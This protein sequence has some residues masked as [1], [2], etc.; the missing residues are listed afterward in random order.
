MGMPFLSRKSQF[1]GHI[2]VYT[3][4]AIVGVA[5][6]VMGIN[7]FGKFMKARCTTELN[8]IRLDLLPSI[9]SLRNVPGSTEVK[10]YRSNC[11]I[12]EIYLV[13][14]GQAVPEMFDSK[15]EIADGI[16][17]K[18]ATNIYIYSQGRLKDSFSANSLSINFPHYACVNAA[19]NKFSFILQGSVGGVD[20]KQD[21]EQ[22]G[23]LPIPATINNGDLENIDSHMNMIENEAK[24]RH[25]ASKAIV[26]QVACK[27][28]KN[29]AQLDILFDHRSDLADF[30]IYYFFP[31][32]CGFDPDGFDIN[33]DLSLSSSLAPLPFSKESIVDGGGAN[34]GFRLKS[35]SVL[36]GQGADVVSLDLTD[37]PLSEACIDY[38]RAFIINND[39]C[40]DPLAQCQSGFLCGEE[41]KCV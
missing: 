16:A 27:L 2:V 7:S 21:N 40:T 8:N 36:E 25:D 18:S 10:A 12:D 32:T 28:S 22:L 37:T 38:C 23:C 33:S 11:G 1:T 13:D 34:I 26:Q 14:N 31:E 24:G 39:M 15:P 29:G 6:L 9:E 41:G 20:A 30:S 3:L 4:V 19:E 5:I 35:Q 17:S